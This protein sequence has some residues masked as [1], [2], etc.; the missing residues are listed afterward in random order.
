MVLVVAGEARA[1]IVLIGAAIG[2]RRLK[3]CIVSNGEVPTIDQVRL[4][5]EIRSVRV[6]YREQVST[7][8]VLMVAVLL[9]IICFIKFLIT[10]STTEK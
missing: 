10:P 8:A 2:A 3:L 5:K 4:L 6:G 1:A 9:D 7:L